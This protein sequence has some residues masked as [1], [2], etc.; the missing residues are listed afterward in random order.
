MKRSKSPTSLVLYFLT[1]VMVA[2]A[3]SNLYIQSASAGGL[4]V[5][6]VNQRYFSDSEGNIVYLTGSHTWA[7]MQDPS[8]DTFDWDGY[9]DLLVSLNHNFFRLWHFEQTKAIVDGTT[10]LSPHPY[11]RTGP[12]NAHDGQLK[13]D[14]TQ[15]NQAYFD[16]MRT[17]IIDAQNHGMYVS[18]MLFNGWSLYKK[19]EW[20]YNCWLDHPYNSAN[21]INGVN[22]D[23]NGDGMGKECNT[24]EPAAIVT[25]QENY[26]K[27]VID[28]VNDLDNVL[29]EICNESDGSTAE[30]N[31][32]Q[33]MVTYI[34]N[35]EAGL[36]NQHPV[37]ITVPWPNGSNAA[38]LSS[39]ADWIS[40]N[41]TAASPYNYETNPPPADG[42]KVIIADTDHL[43]GIGGTVEWVWES[44]TRGENVLYMDP[45]GDYGN[46]D[47][48]IQVNLGYVRT[49][50]N[51]MNLA[52]MTPS[53]TVSST[54]Y[55]LASAGHEYLVFAPSG[56]TF[57]VNLSSA[58]GG[59]SVE[60]FN[61][62]TGKATNG[63]A[64]FGGAQQSFTPPFSG[65]AV[66]YLSAN[67]VFTLNASVVNGHGTIAAS[68]A[69]GPYAKGTVVSLTATPDSGYQVS[70]WKGTDNDSSTATTNTITM[71]ADHTV[72][73]KFETVP[74]AGENKSSNG[75]GGGG[76]FISSSASD[77]P[78]PQWIL[79]LVFSAIVSICV[80]VS[81]DSL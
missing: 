64:I 50:A 78:I 39:N 25:L 17:R 5:S 43:W 63:G 6:P 71:N 15:F 46:S 68:P 56:G 66:L 54:A 69:T 70:A 3:F 21:N 23:T 40:P 77:D 73:V 24:L 4:R 41:E 55:C 81:V 53:T 32:Q 38:L 60:W 19:G 35:Y 9:L 76:C 48:S 12:G 7:N 37:G 2:F 44:F 14:L 42:T 13:F 28:T 72:M 16:R 20:N 31:W 47:T 61:P 51:K 67:E 79:F 33:H 74:N 29:Y 80:H 75:G 11:A 18:I 10:A 34:K 1:F 36:A 52:T 58:M 8:N 49:Y 22:G 26:I 45:Y 27:K 65:D 57:T 62:S 59:F 30:M